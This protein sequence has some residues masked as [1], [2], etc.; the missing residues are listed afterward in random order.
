MPGEAAVAAA[1]VQDAVA[2]P[3]SCSEVGARHRKQSV[4]RSKA[5]MQDGSARTGR[6]VPAM[7]RPYVSSELLVADPWCLLRGLEGGIISLE[8]P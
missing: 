1:D 2:G 4:A 7:P 6:T 5:K 3:G 8:Q